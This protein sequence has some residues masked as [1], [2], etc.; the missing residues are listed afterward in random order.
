MGYIA[1]NKYNQ[2]ETILMAK[3]RNTK[4][5]LLFLGLKVD[6]LELNKTSMYHN[7]SKNQALLFHQNTI[8]SK[9]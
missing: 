4:A 8:I 3:R 7:K 5:I 2:K 6:A 1:N 9:I